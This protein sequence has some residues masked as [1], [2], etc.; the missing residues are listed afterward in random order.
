MMMM[1]MMSHGL[2]PKFICFDSA[3]VATSVIGYTEVSLVGGMLFGVSGL[4]LFVLL[5]YTEI[6]VRVSLLM[7]NLLFTQQILCYMF[8]GSHQ[9]QKRPHLDHDTCLD[10]PRSDPCRQNL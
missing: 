10:S 1:M 6:P 5:P 2:M 9:N 4:L 3:L 7:S 8:G